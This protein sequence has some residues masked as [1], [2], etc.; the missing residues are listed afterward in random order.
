MLPTTPPSSWTPT[1]PHT[2]PKLASYIPL[3]GRRPSVPSSRRQSVSND[4]GAFDDPSGSDGE[5]DAPVLDSSL[6]SNTPSSS[7]SSNI[8]AT[9]IS[10]NSSFEDPLTSP[11]RL[12]DQQTASDSLSAARIPGGYDFEPQTY[13][14]GAPNHSQDRSARPGPRSSRNASVTLGGAH[15]YARPMSLRERLLPSALYARLGLSERET[16]STED[17]GLLFDQDAEDTDT[18]TPYPPRG[19][20]SHIPLPARPPSFAP[21]REASARIFGGGQGNDGVFANL[22]AKP[23]GRQG[24]AEYVGGDDAGG[25]DKDEVPPVSGII[26]ARV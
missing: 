9:P 13:D 22:S 19:T 16:E 15:S 11:T 12:R 10:L 25:G 6:Q 24:G 2:N 5:E 8:P 23:D 14:G 21:P 7:R 26:V 17:R 20:P 1:D 3:F 4:F 18:E